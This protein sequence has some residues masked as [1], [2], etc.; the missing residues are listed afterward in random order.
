MMPE[1][2]ITPFHNKSGEWLGFDAGPYCC[3]VPVTALKNAR[4]NRRK[5]D[6]N[7]VASSF[8]WGYFSSLGEYPPHP[9]R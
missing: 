7:H 1:P 2:D 4:T 5:S 8:A 6:I 3:S 9:Y